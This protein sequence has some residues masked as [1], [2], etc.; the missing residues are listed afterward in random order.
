MIPRIRGRSAQIAE[1]PDKDKYLYEVSLWDFGGENLL[2]EPFLFG[3]FDTENIAKEKGIEIVKYVLEFIE[4]K[5][6]GKISG[7][8]LDMKN[9]GVMRPWVTQ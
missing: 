7:R 4:E 5:E 2:G 1:G 3:P 8:Y 9:G 6:T